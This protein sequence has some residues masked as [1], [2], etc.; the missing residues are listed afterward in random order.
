MMF[1]TEDAATAAAEVAHDITHVIF[2]DDDVDVVNRFQED[3]FSFRYGFLEG[4]GGSDFE[5][6]F[7]RVDGVIRAI[8]QRDFDVD[9]G[10]AGDE[11]FF[12]G[13]ADA[14]FN[15]RDV[16]FRHGTAKNLIDEFKGFARRQR[17]DIQEDMAE[18]TVTAALFLMLT[19]SCRLALD[20]FTIG[21]VD[22]F[23]FRF[24]T[25][26]PFN[27]S[28]DM[29]EVDVA[30]AADEELFAFR[31]LF[32]LAR[33]IFFADLQES[34]HQFFFFTLLFRDQGYRMQRIREADRVIDDG[35]IRS[36]KGIAC[37][38]IR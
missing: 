30:H 17:F 23:L 9:H 18:L 8:G 7:R 3:R 21:D 16:L 22:V 10:E 20:G 15:S 33:R 2:R 31:T 24:D 27:L 35:E 25:V 29:I 14:F 19:F 12:Q 5:G 26:F 11:A 4:L 38:G 34:V 6:H 28:Q 36:R 32:Y 13:F 1:H 37:P